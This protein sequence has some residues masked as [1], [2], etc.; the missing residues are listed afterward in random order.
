MC[1]GCS[2][3]IVSIKN[4]IELHGGYT[5][6]AIRLKIERGVWR[7]GQ[8]IRK[9]PDGHVNIDLKAFERWAE[10]KLD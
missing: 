4:F 2:L 8:V 6:R 5:E 9:L 7:N 10:G 1:T 3:R